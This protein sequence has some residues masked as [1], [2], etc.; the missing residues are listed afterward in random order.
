MPSKKPEHALVRL[1]LVDKLIE[2]GWD[3]GQIQWSPE[4]RVPK[5]PSEASRREAGNSFSGFRVD[6][7]IFE[8]TATAGH[9]E[10]ARILIEAVQSLG[11]LVETLNAPW[12]VDY[13]M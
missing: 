9:W 8:S 2:L 4:W 12:R 7:L 13:P 10:S 1:P 6:V 11:G 5:T 3:E